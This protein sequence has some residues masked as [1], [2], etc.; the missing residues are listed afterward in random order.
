MFDVTAVK[1]GIAPIGWTNDDLP[2]L[3]GENT[4]EQC[5]SEMSLAGFSGTEVGNKYPRD[6]PTLKKALHLRNLE[7]AS[8]WFSA[9]LT[10]KPFEET[11]KAYIAHRDFLYKMGAKVIVV[12]EQGRSI[13]GN[14]ST[15][16]FA[17]KPIFTD[18]EWAKL[19]DGLN[20]LGELAK[21][22]DMK[23]V[24]HHHMGTGVQTTE[25]IDCLMEMTDPNL[26]YLLYDTGHLY[27][28]GEDPL[29]VLEKHFPRIK[30]VHLKDV[31]SEIAREVIQD[32]LSFL[33]GV[34]KGVFTVP[35][36]G[37]INFEPVFQ[38]L[39]KSGYKGWMIVEAEQDPAQANPF[40]Y[41]LKARNFIK[42]AAGV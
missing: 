17:E 11:E 36:D 38:V 7:I 34:K 24:Y 4:F 1:L 8:A 41:A 13:Q 3:G 12:S 21:E 5:I 37:A 9:F 19:A 39:E 6:I 25:E 16:L 35:G 20:R 10:T 33:T 31:R 40:E 14:I 15:P 2:E 22:K 28:S 29:E 42:E 32:R 27:F 23:L 26:V 18:G 30:H